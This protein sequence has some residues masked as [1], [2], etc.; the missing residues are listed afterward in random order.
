MTK[1]DDVPQP[2]CDL[3]VEDERA[4]TLLTEILV[5]HSTDK[6]TVQR[7]DIIPYG[8]SSV[9][10][11]LGQMVNQ[12]RFRRPTRVF[13]DGDAGP[14][15]GCLSLPGIDP[16]EIVVFSALSKDWA[17]L[18]DRVGR[19]DAEVADACDAAM[20]MGD[21]HE[22]VGSAATKLRLKHDTLWQAMCSHWAKGLEAR[23][24]EVIVQGVHDALIGL[25]F[26]ASI[27]PPSVVEEAPQ[28]VAKAEEQATVT[29]KRRKPKPAASSGTGLLF[30]PP[31]DAGQD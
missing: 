31:P 19:S 22:W 15:P 26:Q 6:D 4:Q 30:E 27:P 3:Y 14:A 24:A 7:C 5:E 29:S 28:L 11:S 8:A 13:L 10:K 18:A 1:M 21:H 23:E 16:P 2:E 9:G 25:P 17:G 12:G 20:L